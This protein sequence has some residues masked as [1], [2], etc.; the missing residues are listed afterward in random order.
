[1]EDSPSPVVSE[2]SVTYFVQNDVNTCLEH[3]PNS[4]MESAVDGEE[5]LNRL[6]PRIKSLFE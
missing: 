1:M 2:P 3:V 4:D 6:R 5:L